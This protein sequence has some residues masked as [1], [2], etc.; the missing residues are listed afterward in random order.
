SQALTQNVF[1]RS[2]LAVPKVRADDHNRADAGL[3]FSR[4]K[5]AP[6]YRLHIEYGKE[7]RGDQPGV[8]TFG[9]ARANQA[10]NESAREGHRSK[11]SILFLQIA[12][13]RIRERAILKIWFALIEG[14]QLIGLREGQ[15]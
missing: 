2:K 7:I 9:L 8:D 10:E 14:H 12:K 11:C 13:I 1:R 5:H 6:H 4:C 3:V 15:R